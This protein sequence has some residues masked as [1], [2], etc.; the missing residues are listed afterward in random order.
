SHRLHRAPNGLSHVT[1][2]H[3]RRGEAKGISERL[4]IVEVEVTH[5]EPL[6]QMRPPRNLILNGLAARETAGRIAVPFAADY[7]QQRHDPRAQLTRIERLGE[8]VVRAG[9]ECLDLVCHVVTRREHEHGNAGREW[10]PLDRA[11]DFD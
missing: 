10:I 3:V 8:I 1:N 9:L 7:P 4:E 11:T 6:P 5:S 2:D